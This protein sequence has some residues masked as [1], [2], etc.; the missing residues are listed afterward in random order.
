MTELTS[1]STKNLYSHSLYAF[2]LIEDKHILKFTWTDQHASMNYEDF[3]EA[4]TNYAGFAMEYQ[5]TKLL[6]D[7]QNFVFQLPEAFP[8]WREQYHNPR[9]HKVGVQK[10]AYIMHPDHMQY[11]Q[12]TPA[13]DHHFATFYFTSEAEAIQWLLK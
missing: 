3:Q 5:T 4:C 1:L 9:L 13:K 8:D 2:K 6:V 10:F 12:N 7:T 11:V